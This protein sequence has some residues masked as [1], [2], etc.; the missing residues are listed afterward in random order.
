[1]VIDLAT[2]LVIHSRRS[3]LRGI[4]SAICDTRWDIV[5]AEEPCLE[6]VRGPFRNIDASAVLVQ[7]LSVVVRGGGIVEERATT[8]IPVCILVAIAGLEYSGLSTACNSAASTRMQRDG[9]LGG[10]IHTFDD[11]NLSV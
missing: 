4:R 2:T 8:R 1:M 3:K 7:R 6:V 5:A 10:R 11:V 9:V